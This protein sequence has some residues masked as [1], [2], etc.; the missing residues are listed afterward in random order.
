MNLK[1][2][3]VIKCWMPYFP[4]QY[5]INDKLSGQIVYILELSNKYNN[6]YMVV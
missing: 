1:H 5:N 6:S 3:L 4:I 2:H